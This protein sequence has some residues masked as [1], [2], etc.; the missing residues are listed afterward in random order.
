MNVVDFLKISSL[1]VSLTD[2]NILKNA[3][4]GDFG[5][6]SRISA[7]LEYFPFLKDGDDRHVQHSFS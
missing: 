1:N 3:V 6:I 5:G 7:M 4:K 2:I